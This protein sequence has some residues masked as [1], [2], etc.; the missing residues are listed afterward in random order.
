MKIFVKAKP[1]SHTESVKRIDSNHYAVSV[2]EAPDKGK[3][4]QAI[5]QAL[6][7]HFDIPISKIT[8]ISGFSGKQ[9]VFEIQ[10]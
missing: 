1:K 7:S 3:A 6:A 4:N 10:D 2:Q 8:L 5:I 9:K